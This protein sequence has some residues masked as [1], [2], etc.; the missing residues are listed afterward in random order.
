M[1]RL[2][3]YCSIYTNCKITNSGLLRFL[4]FSISLFNSLI[5]HCFNDDNNTWQKWDLFMFFK[6][7]NRSQWKNGSKLCQCNYIIKN[8][9]EQV[10]QVIIYHVSRIRR[11]LV[12]I[13]KQNVK[14]Y[15]FFRQLKTVSMWLI[16]MPFFLFFFSYRIRKV[17]LHEISKF[18][19]TMHIVVIF[20]DR[21]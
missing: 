19:K 14:I 2:N 6:Q 18:F 9:F 20:N 8:I 21:K 3:A 5:Q 12:V 7:P 1:K 17:N 11:V 15:Y 10:I 16:S 13:A 4:I